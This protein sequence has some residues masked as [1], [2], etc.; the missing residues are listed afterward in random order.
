MILLAD[1]GSESQVRSA[2]ESLC[3]QYWYP[4]YVFVRRQGRA[5]HDAEDCTQEFL[6]RLLEA[7]GIARA[8]REKGRF[9]SFLL[10]GM[11][12][13][14]TN[15][16]HRAQTAKRG[17]GRVAL[18][19]QAEDSEDRYAREPADATLSPEQAF[20][21]DCAVGLIDH[22]VGELRDEYEKSGR[23]TVF[24]TLLPHLWGTPAASGQAEAVPAG[25]TTHAFTV[26]L[27]RA[28]QRLAVRLRQRVAETV[29]DGADV[30]AEL[31]HL[32]AAVGGG[33][34]GT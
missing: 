20:D 26:A 19:L 33:M 3:R 1:Q 23:G 8:R 17:G 32:I 28:R 15:E 9:R 27:H 12:H 24:A 29:A 34:A 22:A 13:F 2:L 30:D 6:A 16:W 25:M 31:R 4:L 11:R 14:L 10:S 18:S 21:R 7:D 5:H